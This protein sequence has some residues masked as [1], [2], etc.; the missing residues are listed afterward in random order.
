MQGSNQTFQY[1]NNMQGSNQ[2]FRTNNKGNTNQRY[3]RYNDNRYQA[4]YENTP[5]AIRDVASNRNR[6]INNRNPS[7]ATVR[8]TENQTGQV[9]DLAMEAQANEV[10]EYLH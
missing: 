6:Y 3:G 9:S 2:T 4:P 7:T 1:R 10:L 5:Q 8:V